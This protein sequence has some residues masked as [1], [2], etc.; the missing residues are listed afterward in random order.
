[1]ISFRIQNGPIKEVG[2][3]GCQVD[4]LIYAARAIIDGLHK[5]FPCRENLMVLGRLADALYWLEI[6]KR[7]REKRGVEGKSKE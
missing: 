6:R 2:V 3:N 4:T 1:M 5:K 7:N